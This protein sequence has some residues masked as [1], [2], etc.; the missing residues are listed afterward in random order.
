ML[1]H[2][3]STASVGV[4]FNQTTGKTD[5]QARILAL[6]YLSGLP[7]LDAAVDLL[8]AVAF[9]GLSGH[10][11][12]LIPSK[13]VIISGGNMTSAG[14]NF[15]STVATL[16]QQYSKIFVYA[17]GD[18]INSTEVS[19]LAS[20]PVAVYTDYVASA[21]D[22][23]Q[24]EI[25]QAASSSLRECNMIPCQSSDTNLILIIDSSN[26]SSTAWTSI[27]GFSVSLISSFVSSGSNIRYYVLS[28]SFLITNN[29]F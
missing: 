4:S 6:P 14:A 12:S 5:L 1:V 15:S 21:S 26:Y 25:Y 11:Y 23:M 28:V 3:A 10:R 16:K 8:V 13:I 9:T 24:D 18:S 17:V 2:G 7:A 27:L 19:L 22:L 29:I 20:T